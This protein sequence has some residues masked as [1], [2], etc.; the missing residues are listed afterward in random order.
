ML[1]PRRPSVRFEAHG[2]VWLYA[3]D[4]FVVVG[5]LKNSVGGVF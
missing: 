4:E 5:V 2:L 1:Q 3:D